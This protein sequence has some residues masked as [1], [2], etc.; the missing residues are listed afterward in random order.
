MRQHLGWLA[1]AWLAVLAGTAVAAK[2]KPAEQAELPFP[3]AL[4]GGKIVV[5]DTAPE[6]LKPPA[7]LKSGVAIAKTP[8]TVDFLYY[9]GQTYRPKLWSNWGDSVVIGGKYYASIG[10]HSAPFGNAFIFEYES[11]TKTFRQLVDVRKLLELP[12][13]HYTPGKIHGRLEQGS[14]GWL[15]FSTHRG[16]AKVTTDE[17]HY[18]GDWILRCHP[19]SGKA[20]VVVQGPVP[21]HSIPNSLLDPQRMIFYGGTAAGVGGDEDQKGIH[22]FAYDVQNKKLLYAGPDGPAR[23][24]ILARSTGRVYY[25]PGN[26]E[27]TLMR[28]DPAQPGPPAKVEGLP[29]I[30]VRAATPETPQGYVYTVSSGQKSPDANLCAFDTRTEKI[31]DLGPAAVGTQAYISTLD[32]DPTGRYLYYIPGAHGSSDRDGTPVVQFD[33]KTRQK[34]VLAFLHPFYHDKYGFTCKGTYSVAV[35][36]RGDTLYITWNISRGGKAW[37]CCGL[38]AIHIPRSER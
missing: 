4:S 19:A 22:F 13:G 26:R 32:V 12:E 36:P 15:Y 28:F 3:P 24:M 10:D 27:G 25:V 23:A 5:T 37:D 9:P 6:F 16:S 2:P 17:Y 8:P 18:R 21:R 29:P 35:D 11:A 38:T 33:V 30:G 31:E 1:M 20:E 34:K 14:D 7:T